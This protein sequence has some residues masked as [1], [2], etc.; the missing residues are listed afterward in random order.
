MATIFSAFNT[1]F[2]R[3]VAMAL[4][5]L[6]A[7]VAPGLSHAA[8]FAGVVTLVIDG[9]TVW[10]RPD[11]GLPPVRVRLQGID[12]PEICQP[13]GKKSRAA[14]A[15]FV[16]HRRVTVTTTG[17]DDY[18]RSLGVIER[19]NDDVNA[20]MVQR[21]YAWSYRFKGDPGPYARQEAQAR[22]ARMGLWRHGRPTEPRDFRVAHGSCKRN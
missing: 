8:K 14:L 1:R 22:R 3:P 17:K 7:L 21:G 2:C 10:V 16:R 15:D 12:A 6:V 19:A 11:N 5:T 18:D 9:D 4:V 20:W 13:Y